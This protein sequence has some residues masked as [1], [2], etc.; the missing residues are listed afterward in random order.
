MRAFRDAGERQLCT[1]I[2]PKSTVYNHGQ[3]C[4][5]INRADLLHKKAI[6][7]QRVI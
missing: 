3:L 4:D 7:K 2:C 5:E 6:K 1:E